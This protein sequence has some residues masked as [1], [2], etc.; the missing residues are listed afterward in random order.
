MKAST[1]FTMA[2]A[3]LIAATPIAGANAQTPKKGGTLT[4]TYQPEPTAISTLAT[5]AVP[6]ALV[7]T[8]IY[9]GLL[10]YAGPGLDPKPGLAESWT[11]SPDNMTY[12]FKLRQ[13]VKWH[14]GMPFTSADVK[15]S[16]ET[17][18]LN[19]HSRGKTY[20]GNVTAIETPDDQTVVIK[21][22]APVPYFLKAFQPSETPIMPKHAFTEQ[23]IAEKKVRQ[24]KIMQEP[25]GTGPFKMKEWKKGSHIILERN[26]DY[27]KPGLPY[28][29]QVVLRVLPDGA[30]RAI[31][32]EKGE[33]DLAP[34]TALPPAE[35]QRLGKLP[36]LVSSQ[37]GSEGLGPIMWLETN[38]REKPLSDL[39]VRQ[40]IS[41]A[42]DREKLVDVIWY[43]MGKPA[44]GPIVS[45][46]PNHFNAALPKL[47]YNPAKANK[48]LDDAGYKRGPDGVRFKLP[49]NF[50]PYGEEWVRQAE[51]IKQELGK[52]GIQADIESLDLGGWLKKVFT[53]WTYQF[54][55]DF[56]HN[57]VDPTIGVQ[58]AFLS[59]NIQKGATFNNSMGYVN[60]KL[61]ELLKKAAATPDGP[62]RKKLWDD[63]QKIMQDDLPVIFLI[64]IGYT[65]IWNKR[66]K[67]LITNGISMYSN[68]DSV[69]LE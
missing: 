41:L 48:L 14:D 12:S 18:A 62:E 4:Y 21:L 30:A 29:D 46:N 43:G 33:V 15:F 49:Q 11:V 40:A 55:S 7:A 9:D 54:T 60:P 61:D 67:G 37:A 51:Y 57:Y 1:I 58:R 3:A 27:W 36:G 26:A 38:L 5:T 20:F 44:R 17:L 31:A 10:E 13:G 45:G 34:M 8:K 19:Y 59:T 6:V 65:H 52:V 68:W 22:K 2:A 63:A 32:V 35:I 28:L 42:I 50:L 25:I 53:D 69:W 66:V 64:E 39:A 56:H 47:E 24:A 16:I 23:E